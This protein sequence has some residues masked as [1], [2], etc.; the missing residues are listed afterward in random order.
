[1]QNWDEVFEEEIVAAVNAPNAEAA[2][3]EFRVNNLRGAVNGI[4]IALSRNFLNTHPGP[5]QFYEYRGA[6]MAL[7]HLEKAIL[8]PAPERKEDL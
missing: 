7:L 5:E 4:L 2:R 1:M 8:P 6:V 3:H